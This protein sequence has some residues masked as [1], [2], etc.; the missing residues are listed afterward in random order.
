VP[1]KRRNKM[2]SSKTNVTARKRVVNKNC[3]YC[4]NP[5]EIVMS[6]SASGK[7]KLVR[8]CCGK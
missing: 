3:K 7:K 4:K 5:V 6:V 8:K 2:A 1:N